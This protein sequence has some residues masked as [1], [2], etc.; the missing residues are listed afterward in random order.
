MNQYQEVV[1]EAARA[2]VHPENREK[3]R[4]QLLSGQ[5]IVPVDSPEVSLRLFSTG[6]G[7]ANLE[8]LI[9]TRLGHFFKPIGYYTSKGDVV[10]L[11]EFEPP[12]ISLWKAGAVDKTIPIRRMGQDESTVIG[13]FS[14]DTLLLAVQGDET[15]YTANGIDLELVI[16]HD[17]NPQ[18]WC[19]H[20]RDSVAIYTLREQM[21]SPTVRF[22]TVFDKLSMLSLLPIY[23]SI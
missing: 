13:A 11:K 10:V 15:T 14:V 1:E 4:K 9:S 16:N 8:M 2:L 7:T 20:Y 5:E 12:L 3:A 22:Q 17:G 23:K 21:V 18:I 19:E 6:S